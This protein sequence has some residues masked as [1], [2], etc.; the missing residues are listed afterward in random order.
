MNAITE[1]AVKRFTE[2]IQTGFEKGI[3]D[4]VSSQEALSKLNTLDFPTTRVEAWKYTRVTKISKKD[5]SI[6]KQH[7]SD[8]SP[9]KVKNESCFS[10][11][12]PVSGWN[13]CV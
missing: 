5:F 13:Q 1:S 4:E 8:I 10:A 9:F 7:V 2:S 12:V 11:V 6:Q 3:I